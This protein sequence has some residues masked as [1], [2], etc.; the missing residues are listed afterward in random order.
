M[1]TIN[2]VSIHI[3]SVPYLH[4]PL[5]CLCTQEVR[6][7]VRILVFQH[8]E[9]DCWSLCTRSILIESNT[10]DLLWQNSR[11]FEGLFLFLLKALGGSEIN[12][13]KGMYLSLIHI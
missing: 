8:L 3:Y 13:N 12:N 10:G 1:Q 2:I 7:L 6:A 4:R 11:T 5:N 9:G